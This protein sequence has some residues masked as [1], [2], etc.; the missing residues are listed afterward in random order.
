MTY[1]NIETRRI[2]GNKI[3][4]SADGRSWRVYGKTGNYTARANI[5]EQGKINLLI[6]MINLLELSNELK[7]I[8]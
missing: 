6:G 2:N 4:Y 5:T 1:T 8:K 3:A 7:D